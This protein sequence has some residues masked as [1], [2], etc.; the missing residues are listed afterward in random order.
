MLRARLALGLLS[1]LLLLAGVGAYALW[2]TREV[3]YAVSGRVVAHARG[4]VADRQ[5]KEQAERLGEA[6]RQVRQYDF[7][8][9]R[10][11][12]AGGLDAMRRALREQ[13][14]ADADAARGGR[15]A[16]VSQTL[17]AF[18]ARA[19]SE[20]SAQ[21]EPLEQM[22]RDGSALFAVQQAVTELSDYDAA[23]LIS[24][25]QGTHQ[26][27]KRAAAVFASGLAA[28]LILAAGLAWYTGRLL[29]KPIRQLTASAAAL[30]EGR[31]DQDVP[32]ASRDELGQLAATFNTMAARLRAYRDAMTEK[33]LRAQRTM[34]ATLTTTPDPLFVL[35]AAGRTTVRNPAAVALEA[36]PEFTGG[37]PAGLAGPLAEVL[38]RGEHYLPADYSRAVTVRGRHYLPRILAIGDQLSDFRGA[39]VILQDV[40]KFRLLDDAKSNLAG[41]VGHELKTPL[42]SLRLSVYLLLE[43]QVGR[44]EPAQRELLETAR[45][46]A[47]RLLR[48]LDDL[49]DLTRLESGGTLVTPAPEPPAELLADMAAE[50]KPLADERRQTLRAQIAPGLPAAVA[51]DRER[52][53][54]VFI[55]LLGNASKY[56]PPGGVIELYAE[57]AADGWVRFG[58]RD[59]GPGLAESDLARVFEKFYRAPGQLEKG[60]GLGLAIAREIVVAHGGT[61]ACRNRPEGG[62]D[63]YFM[64]P[65]PLVTT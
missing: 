9:T 57:P 41:T 24:A 37:F 43:E 15:L 2:T 51:V 59:D 56:S 47:D 40:T 48:I 17:D 58:V 63:F 39:A 44:L 49:L 23:A 3:G 31:L 16:A 14:A 25:E 27:A 61:I 21:E 1:L 55:N 10:K 46:A 50:I 30:G 7:A 38:A 6:L 8:N 54:H 13:A 45:E 26:A 12:L 5:L 62:A 20:Q 22:R 18:A 19:D 60:A 28:A 53:R 34:E 32:V 64:I 35:D 52:I 11:T 65:G 4:L 29:M 36:A 33:A 42:T